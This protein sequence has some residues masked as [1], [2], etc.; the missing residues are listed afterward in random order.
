MT[1]SSIRLLSMTLLSAVLLPSSAAQA[2]WRD[3][4]YLDEGYVIE[5]YPPGYLREGPAV[6]YPAPRSW[7][8]PVFYDRRG[9][10]VY[11]DP[12]M[13]DEGYVDDEP[14]EVLPY[15]PPEASRPAF[16]RDRNEARLPRSGDA[17][18]VVP[19]LAPR[20]KPAG[21]RIVTLK[22]DDLAPSARPSVAKSVALPVPR[23]NLEGMDFAPTTGSV[24]VIP[25]AGQ[26]EEGR[27]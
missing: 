20:R 11:V 26:I 25:P 8:G 22:P 2:W 3:R 21:P 17:P 27:R 10:Q 6:V 4:A 1:P 24:A 15:A 18:T 14:L 13:N 16:R 9:P 5:S 7:D 23:P 12:Y 19:G